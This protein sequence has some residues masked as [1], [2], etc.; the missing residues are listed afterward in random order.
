[1][2]LENAFCPLLNS[3]NNFYQELQIGVEKEEASHIKIRNTQSGSLA[4]N[5]NCHCV[6]MRYSE[7]YV[8]CTEILEFPSNIPSDATEIVLDNSPLLRIDITNWSRFVN[9]T[10]LSMR[11]VGITSLHRDQFV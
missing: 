6:R 7:L 1:M 4:C 8:K 11:D 2:E 10:S 3:L 5:E 9:L